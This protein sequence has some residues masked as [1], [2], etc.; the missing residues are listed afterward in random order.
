MVARTRNTVFPWLA[1][2]VFS[3]C[4]GSTENT[5]GVGGG[6]GVEASAA[7]SKT[8]DV[9]APPNSDASLSGGA[10]G[11]AGARDAATANAE[12]STSAGADVEPRAVPMLPAGISREQSI[13]SLSDDEL[14]TV[15]EWGFQNNE[16]CVSAGV[17]N[18]RIA[19]CVESASSVLGPCGITVQDWAG[20]TLHMD[21]E[22]TLFDTLP[23]CEAMRRC[24]AAGP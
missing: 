17:T 8:P 19:G 7:A 1:A 9:V 4:G 23:E 15:C 21:C 20:C 12:A 11:A 10:A 6:D 13:G 16:E 2:M 24:L 5:D 3:A 18:E 14:R 22:G